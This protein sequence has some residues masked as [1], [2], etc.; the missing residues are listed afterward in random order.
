MQ[1]VYSEEYGPHTTNVN[2]TKIEPLG[3]VEHLS[4]N[5]Q[6]TVNSFVQVSHLFIP[7]L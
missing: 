1:P 3:N 7:Q 6:G 2:M 5:P 4:R